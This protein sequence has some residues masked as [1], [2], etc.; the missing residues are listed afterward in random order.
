MWQSR[1]GSLVG[2]QTNA[3]SEKV[4]WNIVFS[5]TNDL[6]DIEDVD[7]SS[8]KLLSG[9]GKVSL[10]LGQHIHWNGHWYLDFLH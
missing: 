4:P 1:A 3:I 6:E 10:R 2:S 8:E 5:F 9:E 7:E